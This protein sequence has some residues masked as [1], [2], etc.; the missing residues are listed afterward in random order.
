MVVKG[1]ESRFQSDDPK[2]GMVKLPHLFKIRV[3]GVVGRDAVYD[4]ILEG[5]NAGLAV[6]FSAQGRF[7]L[8]V[9]VKSQAGILSEDQ[10][11][12]CDFA[13]DIE[14]QLLGLPHQFDGA[15]GADMRDM[16]AGAC[17]FR[18]HDIAGNDHFLSQGGNA[19]K[20]KL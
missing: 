2:G 10:V 9:G 20:A 17:V 18:Q 7:H 19:G 15:G 14:A 16:K 13:G 3:G 1:G 12:G 6:C 4:S 11:M 5:L 8:G